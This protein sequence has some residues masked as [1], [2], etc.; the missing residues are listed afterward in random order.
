MPLIMVPNEAPKTFTTHAFRLTI[1]K[2]PDL[3]NIHPHFEF[4]APY[5]KRPPDSPDEPTPTR[6]LTG[7]SYIYVEYFE[8]LYSWSNS[9]PLS[10]EFAVVTLL[11]LQANTKDLD[12]TMVDP[13]IKIFKQYD[14]YSNALCLYWDRFAM[15]TAG[16]T[17]STK[18]VMN[19]GDSCITTHLTDIAV[20]LDGRIPSGHSLIDA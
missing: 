4:P 3:T 1:G 16:G 19:D 14:L 11:A 18:G 12:L 6:P 2:T 10:S 9:N 7:F 8:N 15:N 13:P 20:F 17:W 5:F